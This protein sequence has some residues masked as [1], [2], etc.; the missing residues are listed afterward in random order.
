MNERKWIDIEPGES[1]L[2]LCVRGLEESR[3]SSSTLS[4]STTRRRWSSSILEDQ[5][6]YSESI[7]TNS[8]LV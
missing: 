7:S 4:D 6:L 1:S 2:S 8:L 3:Q 5:E